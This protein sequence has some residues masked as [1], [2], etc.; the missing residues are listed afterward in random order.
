MNKLPLISCVMPTY[1]R[2]NYVDE[3]VG[4]FV[5]Q[6]YPAKELV[7][8]NDCPGQVFHSDRADVRVIN[9]DTRFPTLG[10]KR[11]VS[12][13]FAQ[14]EYIAVWD[15]DDAYLP[16][17][18]SFSYSELQRLRTPFYRPEHFL[19]YSGQADMVDAVC[20]PGGI[21]HSTVLF[22]KDLWKDA[23]GYPARN[24]RSDRYF[25]ERI[26]ACLGETFLYYAIHPSDR[27]YILRVRSHYRHWSIP[28]GLFP[29]DTAPGEF[30]IVPR[31]IAD[32]VL[33]RAFQKH[34]EARLSSR[35]WCSAVSE[36]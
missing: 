18:L 15:D 6:D 3:A 35:Q 17:R 25:F 7:I 1:G 29:L 2:P 20:A 28:G 27:Y 31:P 8:L 26:D 33:R 21:S 4:M 11:N 36:L 14:G 9:Y 34:S 10:E 24:D 32:P 30:A 5:Q 16:W 23:G 19:I 22:R 13:E 12:V